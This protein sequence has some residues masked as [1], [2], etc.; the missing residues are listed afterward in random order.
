M[1][2]SSKVNVNNTA[3]ETPLFLAVQNNDLNMAKVLVELGRAR[4]DLLSGEEGASPLYLACDR[5]YAGM[6]RYGT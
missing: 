6:A 4:T 3:G 5:G 2:F 1:I